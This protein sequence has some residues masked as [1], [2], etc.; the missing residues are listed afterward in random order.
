M[1]STLLF[2]LPM[3]PPQQTIQYIHILHKN[4]LAFWL[5]KLICTDF[6]S[7]KK[8]VRNP[9]GPSQKCSRWCRKCFDK[10]VVTIVDFSW[11]EQR[12]WMSHINCVTH[13]IASLWL[14]HTEICFHT[15]AAKALSKPSPAVIFQFWANHCMSRS[16][17]NSQ[18]VKLLKHPMNSQ[19]VK[20]FKQHLE[21]VNLVNTKP[22]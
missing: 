7:I 19:R 2:T 1:E 21:R 17:R 16:P 4:F 5:W 8:Y 15:F 22:I 14:A 18:R 12:S 10:Y 6:F 9:S 11:K 20:L 13:P 3:F